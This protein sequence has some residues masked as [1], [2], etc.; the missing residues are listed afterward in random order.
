MAK[1]K[2]TA[3]WE[4]SLRE[5]GGTLAVGS[6][7]FEGPYSFKSRF[8]EGTG[9]N[10][11]EL[12]GAAHAG[13]FTMALSLILGEAGHEP[14]S[15]ETEAQVELRAGD[16][17]VEIRRIE[18][19]TTGRVPGISADEFRDHAEAAKKGCAVSRA[20]AGVSEITLQASLEE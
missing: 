13:C 3:R 18:L 8:E 4:G 11:E 5:G 20:L 1:R 15:L 2:A 14:E 17:G 10:P 12:I 7:A 19:Q 9:T 16:E 6:G